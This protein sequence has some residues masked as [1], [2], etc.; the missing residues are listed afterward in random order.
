MFP[1]CLIS[2]EKKILFNQIFY[3]IYFH[4]EVFFC[5]WI[6][7]DITAYRDIFTFFFIIASFAVVVIMRRI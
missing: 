2:C 4:D 3:N 7:Y 5:Y 6:Y 1:M